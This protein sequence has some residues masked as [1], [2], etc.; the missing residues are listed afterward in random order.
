M[1]TPDEYAGGTPSSTCTMAACADGRVT[2]IGT[3]RSRSHG[4]AMLVVTSARTQTC[5]SDASAGSDISLT[6]ARGARAGPVSTQKSPIA[7]QPPQR[8]EYSNT[9]WARARTTGIAQGDSPWPA[10][11][12]GT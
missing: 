3:R 4:A 10:R 5:Q 2:V 8:C 9:R 6:S 7:D 12:A 1:P 11:S